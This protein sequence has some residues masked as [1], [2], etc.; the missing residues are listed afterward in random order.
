MVNL[1]NNLGIIKGSYW[2]A[3]E[4]IIKKWINIVLKK[5]D[6]YLLVTEKGK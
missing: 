2:F 4:E 1:K 3:D 5:N 6:E